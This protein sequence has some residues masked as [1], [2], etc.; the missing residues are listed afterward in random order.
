MTKNTSFP[1]LLSRPDF[2]HKSS[3]ESV[4]REIFEAPGSL[5][6]MRWIFYVSLKIPILVICLSSNRS[7]FSWIR[8]PNGRNWKRP[9]WALG[10]EKERLSISHTDLCR[11]QDI[12]V[13]WILLWSTWNVH[14]LLKRIRKSNQSHRL[15]NLV[16]LSHGWF[17][18]SAP[19]TLIVDFAHHPNKNF[20]QMI[21]TFGRWSQT[22]NW[23]TLRL[24][25][26]REYAPPKLGENIGLRTPALSGLMACCI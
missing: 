3:D 26:C 5:L 25:I 7:I 15:A 23:E 9:E 21:F 16:Y 14:L 20:N 19:R 22:W 11:F 12:L 6:V 13:E 1:P 4:D 18:P 10:G 8:N 2:S 24:K 17:L